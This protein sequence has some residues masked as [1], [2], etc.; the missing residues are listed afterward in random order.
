MKHEKV[1]YQIDGKSFNGYWAF[2]EGEDTTVQQR[3]TI[4]VAHAWMGQDHFARQKADALA[5]LGY[6][7]F[8]A[9]MYGEGKTASNADE[10]K[11]LVLPL[12]QDRALLQK[13][14]RGALEA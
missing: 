13:R 6:I 2:P 10:A 11:S 9:D 3:P 1:S 5:E 4:I 8:A 7:A 14:I 12:F